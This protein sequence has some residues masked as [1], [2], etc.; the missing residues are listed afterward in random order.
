LDCDLPGFKSIGGVEQKQLSFFKASGQDGV[1]EEC[2]AELLTAIKTVL[3]ERLV[4]YINS[5]PFFRSDIFLVI[6][7]LLAIK[8]VIFTAC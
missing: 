4:K 8:M 2:V 1:K 6:L 5:F 3:Q 7:S